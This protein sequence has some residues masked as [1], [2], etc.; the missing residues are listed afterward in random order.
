MMIKSKR[1]TTLFILSICLFSSTVF[2]QTPKEYEQTLP[3]N[4]NG[5]V[6]IKTY[7]GSITVET[8]NKAEVYFYA[9]VEP[10]T[11]GWNNT[12]PE[13]QLEKC[14]VEFDHSDNYLSLESDY[15]KNYGGSETRAFVH[16]TVKMPATASLRIDDYKSKTHISN[17]NSDIDLETYKGVVNIVNYSG[18]IDLETYKGTVEIDY[19]EFNNNCKLET[20]KGDYLLTLPS[21]SKFNFDFDLGRKGDFES[22]FEMAMS[23]YKSDDGEVYGSVNGG[24]PKINFS[25]YKGEIN[26]EKK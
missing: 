2:S 25:T 19:S 4:E 26:L 18:K 22:D 5:T 11:D 15:K 24:G 14:K 8:W 1:L 7:K 9:K 16:Y 3:L 17:L 13:E 6:S 20:Y 12:S 21:N 10:D 23:R